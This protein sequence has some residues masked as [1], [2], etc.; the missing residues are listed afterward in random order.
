MAIRIGRREFITVIG[1]AVASWPFAVQAQRAPKLPTI[2]FLGADATVW[3]PWTAAFVERLRELSW[4]EGHTVAIEYRW[5]EGRAERVGEIG[6]EFVRMK[7]DLI[8]TNGPAVLK[9]KQA[10]AVIPIVFALADDPVGGG[11][12]ASLARPGGNVTGLSLQASDLASKRLGL[13]REVVPHLRRLA[14]M[15]SSVGYSGAERETREAQ[16]AARTL[17]VEVVPLEIRQARDIAPAFEVLKGQVD[18]LY[19][20]VDALIAANRTRIITLA[21]G[22]RLPTIFNTREH[23]QAGALMS[24]GPRYLDLFRRAAEMV[25]KIM[26]GT[27]PADIPV[28]QPTKFELVVNLTTAKAI[29]LTIPESFLLRADEVIE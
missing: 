11:M 19:V 17:D 9:L 21:T 6:A 5:Y 23:A 14:I 8:V 20:V 16:E 18:A 28:E 7:I 29:G 1:G 3:S 27:K 12:V 4:I 25:D 10:T 26:R 2:G 15:A 24:Y 13:L 22:A